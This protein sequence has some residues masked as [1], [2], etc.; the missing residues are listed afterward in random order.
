MS[1]RRAFLK[2]VAGLVA[3]GTAT[4]AALDSA[5]PSTGGGRERGRD[6]QR[7]VRESLT[8]VTIRDLARIG[9]VYAGRADVRIVKQVGH[10]PVIH[11]E[12]DAFV[13][14]EL[15]KVFSI[16]WNVGSEEHF[17]VDARLIRIELRTVNMT[18]RVVFRAGAS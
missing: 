4:P 2:K 12:L 13:P 10:V 9:R 17:Y 8:I 6:F 11:M 14:L 16:V 18:T 7:A 15:H 5:S 1:G 3:V